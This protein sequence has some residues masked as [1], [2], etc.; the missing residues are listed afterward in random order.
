MGMAFEAALP[1]VQQV[2][3]GSSASVVGGIA[4]R[5]IQTGSV[6]KAMENPKDI[7]TD[8][9]VG[10]VSAGGA[11]VADAAVAAKNAGRVAT[12]ERNV[13]NSQT[14]KSTLKQLNRLNTA[15]AQIADQQAKVGFGIGLASGV[16]EKKVTTP[17]QEKL[18]EK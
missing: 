11:V 8:A 7:A 5:T 2:V 18:D 15:T 9:V 3:V 12:L 1:G 14:T 13:A 17:T 4:D 10:A 16:A 6:N